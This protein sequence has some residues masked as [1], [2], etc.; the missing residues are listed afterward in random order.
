VGGTNQ[1]FGINASAELY[2]PA[3]GQWRFTGSL[4]EARTQHQA[5][6]LKDGRVLV[7]GGEDANSVVLS[8]AEVYD[9][10]TELWT[11][12][13]SMNT[14]RIAFTLSLLKNGKALAVGGY[15]GCQP[16]NYLKSTDLY[17]PSSGTWAPSGNLT[18]GRS[19]HAAAKLA[20]GKLVVSGGFD[21]D[22]ATASVEVYDPNHQ[23]WITVGPMRSKR[24]VHTMTRLQDGRML[25]TA[26]DD[27]FDNAYRTAELGTA[28]P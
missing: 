16:C 21:G 2:D 7:T 15:N 19:G 14:E 1:S 3:T 24:V 9:P 12:T 4:S 18:I 11:T 23:A 5:V 28:A 20:G 6:L 10:V 25:V 13:G 27:G 8:S 17:D 26:G 22:N